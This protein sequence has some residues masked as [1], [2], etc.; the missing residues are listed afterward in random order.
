MELI[1][2][3]LQNILK[4][5]PLIAE[6]GGY[7]E[8]ISR[9]DLCRILEEQTLA[10]QSVIKA[11]IGMVEL[12]WTKAGLLEPFELKLGNWQFLSFSSSLAARSWLEVM[13]DKDSCW[14]PGGWWSDQANSENQRKLHVLR[15]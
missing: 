14:F 7:K 2:K 9:D 10:S 3:I 4:N 13:S 15:I 5:L 11:V 6:E 1:D 8:N 12:Q